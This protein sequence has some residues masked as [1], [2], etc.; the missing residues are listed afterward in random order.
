MSVAIFP[1]GRLYLVSTV[2]EPRLFWKTRK[3]NMIWI[4]YKKEETPLEEK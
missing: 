3:Q 1:F 2:Y 4:M